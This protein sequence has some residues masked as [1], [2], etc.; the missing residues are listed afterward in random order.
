MEVVT[1]Y[2][3]PWTVTSQMCI[4]SA[5]G[6]HPV[7]FGHDYDDYGSIDEV[8]AKHI[9]IACNAFPEL[10]AAL[11]ALL[12]IYGPLHGTLAG[13]IPHVRQA[14]ENAEAAIAKAEGR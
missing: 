9:V 14:W 1:E 10:I 3:L 8:T 5:D 6:Q 11:K 13:Y 12:E 7:C 2:P 4:A